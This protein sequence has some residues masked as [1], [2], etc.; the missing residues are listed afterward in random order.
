M[1]NNSKCMNYEGIL[2]IIR[3]RNRPWDTFEHSPC[4]GLEVH[5]PRAYT[6]DLPTR[7]VGDD[8]ILYFHGRTL[9]AVPGENGFGPLEMYSPLQCL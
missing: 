7:R 8:M 2:G 1:N 6:R 9:R 5:Q 4:F 3:H